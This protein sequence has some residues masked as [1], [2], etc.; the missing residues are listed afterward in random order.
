[1]NYYEARELV[2]ENGKGTGQFHYTVRNDDRI[3]PVGY[4]STY[5]EPSDDPYW[6]EEA[7]A[8]HRSRKDKYHGPKG[9]DSKIEA[10]NCYRE[11]ELDRLRFYDER[12]LKEK[13]SRLQLCEIEGC[14]NYTASCANVPGRIRDWMLCTQH[15]NRESVEK[16]YPQSEFSS[17][18]SG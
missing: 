5:M 13:P 12:T 2:D 11:Y 4:C 14:E 6:T 3:Y 8:E 17:F 15:L 1:M 16:L 10:C 9:H 18:G 7:K